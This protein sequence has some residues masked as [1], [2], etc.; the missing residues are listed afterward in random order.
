L[1]D[2]GRQ[3]EEEEEEVGPAAGHTFKQR[4]GKAVL[5]SGNKG[6]V[7]WEGESGR[8]RE[9]D[10]LGQAAV[11]GQ[12]DRAAIAGKAAFLFLNLN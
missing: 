1:I 12:G 6:K 8:P 5:Q 3:H 4:P 2:P 10:G 7:T 9:G 11:T